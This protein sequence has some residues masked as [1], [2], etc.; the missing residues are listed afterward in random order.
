MFEL[1][2]YTQTSQFSLLLALCL[3][4]SEKKRNE[5]PISCFLFY[6]VHRCDIITIQTRYCT[7][8]TLQYGNNTWISDLKS[9]KEILHSPMI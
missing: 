6:K 2:L 3:F 8:V 5:M 4:Q 7:S 1:K 9:H